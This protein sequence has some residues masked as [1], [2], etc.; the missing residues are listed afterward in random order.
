[1]TFNQNKSRAQLG[2]SEMQTIGNTVHT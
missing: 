2:Y 1:M